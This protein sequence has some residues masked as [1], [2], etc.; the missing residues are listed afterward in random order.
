MIDVYFPSDF[1]ENLFRSLEAQYGCYTVYPDTSFPNGEVLHMKGY[2]HFGKKLSL[3]QLMKRCIS[4]QWSPSQ[5]TA[6]ENATK[7]KNLAPNQFVEWGDIPSQTVRR[8]KIPKS[9]SVREE[10]TEK[11][12]TTGATETLVQEVAENVLKNE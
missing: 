3:M 1:H 6:I 5:G 10:I 11:D 8:Q 12:A 7:I 4:F 9:N 2:I